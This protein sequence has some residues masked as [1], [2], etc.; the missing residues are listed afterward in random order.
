[1]SAPGWYPDPEG[2]GRPRFWD[3]RAWAP[4][5]GAPEPPAPGR[6]PG[7]GFGWLLG[8]LAVVALVVVLLVWRPWQ[9]GDPFPLPTDG[10]SA[11]PT[12][13]QWNELEPTATPPSPLPTD[14]GGR[15]VAC[16]I[17]QEDPLGPRD[18][19]YVSGDIG[20]K[21]IPGWADGG[22]WTIDFASQRSSQVDTVAQDWVAVAA[23]GR[24]DRADYGPDARTAAH[25]I[26]SCL[27][28]SYFY[29]PLDHA[30]TLE[31][32]AFTTRDQIPGWLIRQN[33]WNVPNQSVVGDEVVVVV[34]DDG[35]QLTLMHTEAPIGDE[36]RG[37]LVFRALESL[38]RR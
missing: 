31:D 38:G 32:E 4:A 9:G 20:F 8:G 2:S 6:G 27:A 19:Y 37:E 30:E 21:A 11:R 15:P 36:R 5:A 16:P 24:L 26:I 7:R 14:E 34:L 18:G 3:G 10:N 33:F 12:G 35:E 17:V 22:G 28:S 13:S 23:I 29:S 25:Q 1:M